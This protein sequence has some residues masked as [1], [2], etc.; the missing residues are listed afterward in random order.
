MLPRNRGLKFCRALSRRIS[1]MGFAAPVSLKNARCCFSTIRTGLMNG[2]DR[3]DAPNAAAGLIVPSSPRTKE[4]PSRMPNLGTRLKPTPMR[5][6][7]SP[8]S[9]AATGAAR[10]T[11]VAPRRALGVLLDELPVRRDGIVQHG[12]EGRPAQVGRHGLELRQ[13]VLGGDDEV[14]GV[15][16][17]HAHGGGWGRGGRREE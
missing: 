16:L 15:G 6:G 8:D 7:A 11:A 2:A 14:V 10:K 5:R 17:V 3:T 4:M 12:L 1:R 13:A 9:D